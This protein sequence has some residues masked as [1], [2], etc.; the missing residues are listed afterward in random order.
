MRLFESV[1]L[2]KHVIKVNI[3]VNASYPLLDIGLFIG[4]TIIENK[5][6]GVAYCL[7]VLVVFM[8]PTGK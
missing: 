5:I 2:H 4:Y 8:T 3:S 6:P 1:Y 7:V